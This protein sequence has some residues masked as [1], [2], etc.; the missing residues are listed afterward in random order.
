MFALTQ[1]KQILE[2]SFIATV[3][4]AKMEFFFEVETP[5]K[6]EDL[7]S[8]AFRFR[9]DGKHLTTKLFENPT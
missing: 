9:L 6:P 1:K 8:S 4:E 2:H 5:F 7:K 3:T